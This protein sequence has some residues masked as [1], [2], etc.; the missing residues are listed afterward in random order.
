MKCIKGC[1]Q[2]ATVGAYCATHAPKTKPSLRQQ[3]RGI[4][5]VIIDRDIAPPHGDVSDEPRDTGQGADW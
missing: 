2:E 3:D 1:G 5:S 4:P